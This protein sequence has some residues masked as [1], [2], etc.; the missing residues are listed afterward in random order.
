MFLL[1]EQLMNN[2][3]LLLFLELVVRIQVV[4]V[5]ETLLS[6]VAVVQYLENHVL[7]TL[8]VILVKQELL[9]IIY[10]EIGLLDIIIPRT[11]G[12]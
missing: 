6:D 4:G 1:I 9:Y 8:P 2:M 12:T 7:V 3:V 5:L 11:N 10:E